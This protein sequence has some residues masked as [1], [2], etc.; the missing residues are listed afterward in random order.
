M[1]K[2]L[3]KSLK[4]K[5]YKFFIDS[6]TN[7]QFIILENKRIK[8]LQKLVNFSI[9]ENYNDDNSVIR[10]VTDWYITYEDIDKV[11]KLF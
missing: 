2:R 11:I 3:K 6:P 1:A 7:Q 8:E 10:L 5:N 9:W 4:S